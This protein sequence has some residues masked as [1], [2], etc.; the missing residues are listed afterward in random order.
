MHRVHMAQNSADFLAVEHCGQALFSLS[1]QNVKEM[2]I[3]LEEVDEEEADPG[4]PRS[5]SCWGTSE[6]RFYGAGNRPV[7]LLR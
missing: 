2:P 6:R 5:A 4:S 7:V 3:A 1:A